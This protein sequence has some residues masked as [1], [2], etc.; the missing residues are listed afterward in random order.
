MKV[1][2]T[3]NIAT[4]L[5]ITNGACGEI[6]DII[7]HPD[8]PTLHSGSIVHLRHLPICILVKLTRTRASILN[9]LDEHVVPIKP[10]STTIQ[11]DLSMMGTS[12]ARRSV[13]QRQFPITPAYAF[14]DYHSQG[15]TISYVIV[16]LASPPSGSLSLFNIYVAL[17]RSSG[18]STIR[19]LRD[20]DNQLF[21]QSF[22]PSLIQEDERLE[23]L[24]RKTESRQQKK[25]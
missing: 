23:L 20:F 25:N 18:R 5:D 15:Q 19:L 1:L 14:T 4:D 22:E 2:V 6:I 16:D 17:S 13:V 3:N 8:E 11:I 9:N 12:K 24:D 10:L 7:L 21:T